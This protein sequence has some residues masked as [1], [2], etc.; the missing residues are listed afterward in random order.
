MLLATLCIAAYLLL[1]LS[2][3]AGGGGGGS[4][5]APQNVFLLLQSSWGRILWLSTSGILSCWRLGA[6]ELF[7]VGNDVHSV[8]SYSYSTNPSLQ[9]S[10]DAFLSMCSMAAEVQDQPNVQQPHWQLQ[11]QNDQG[12]GWGNL[13][14]DLVSITTAQ[15]AKIVRRWHFFHL[16]DGYSQG[17]CNRLLL[18]AQLPYLVGKTAILIITYSRVQ[19][20]NRTEIGD[21]TN[22]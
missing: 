19:S 13:C 10:F 7:L 21:R 14:S 2:Q 1:L 6:P 12:E 3:E 9:P 22:T 16:M 18:M 20:N 4:G 17:L 11:L 8:F 5:D 15:Y